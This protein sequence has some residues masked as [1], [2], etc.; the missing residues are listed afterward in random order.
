MGQ[1]QAYRLVGS[2]AHRPELPSEI[3]IAGVSKEKALVALEGLH[4]RIRFSSLP[5]RS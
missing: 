4:R 3:E 5:D 2:Q 1:R